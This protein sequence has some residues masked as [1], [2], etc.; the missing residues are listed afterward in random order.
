M[1]SQYID[2]DTEKGVCVCA[3]VHVHVV[4]TSKDSSSEAWAM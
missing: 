3:C 1:D 2:R 4:V